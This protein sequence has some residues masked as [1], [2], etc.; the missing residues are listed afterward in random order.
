[1]VVIRHCC[2]CGRGGIAFRALLGAMILTLACEGERWTGVVY[3][4]R[5]NLLLYRELGEFASLE[6]CRESAQSYLREIGAAERGDY[7][8]GKNCRRS[9]AF[10]LLK[11]CEDTTR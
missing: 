6:E 10:S 1:M 2:E 7:E 8:C 11:V 5:G 4:D 9:D 3:P